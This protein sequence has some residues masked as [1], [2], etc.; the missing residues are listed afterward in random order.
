[1]DIKYSV[2]PAKN[3][4]GITVYRAYENNNFLDEFMS[5]ERAWNYIETYRRLMR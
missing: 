1:M 3:A 4:K 2:K 5:E